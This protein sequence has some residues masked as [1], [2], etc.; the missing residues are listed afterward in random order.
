MKEKIRV[1]EAQ[2][3]EGE[4]LPDLDGARRSGKTQKAGWEWEENYCSGTV[5]DKG[6][7]AISAS[8]LMCRM[9]LRAQRN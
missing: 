7:V 3:R 4:Q 9:T 2:S 1:A 8:A 5:L 6:F